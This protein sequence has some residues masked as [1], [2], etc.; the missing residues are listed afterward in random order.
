M[1]TL[2]VNNEDNMQELSTNQNTIIKYAR[3]LFM[4]NMIFLTKIDKTPN[5]KILNVT[6]SQTETI[7]IVAI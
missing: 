6:D 3:N 1:K 7:T 4:F 2:A 5:K